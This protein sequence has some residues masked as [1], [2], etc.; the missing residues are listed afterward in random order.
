MN[1]TDLVVLPPTSDNIDLASCQAQLAS[2]RVAHKERKDE[3]TVSMWS[4]SKLVAFV[5]TA[6]L[7]SSR[8]TTAF[9]VGSS[10]S[11]RSV[12]S[13]PPATAPFVSSPLFASTD[14]QPA[15]KQSLAQSI[16]LYFAPAD[17]LT[18]QQRLAKMGLMAA[19]SYGWVSNTSYCVT[20]SIAWYLFSKRVRSKCR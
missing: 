17:G 11:R 2:I 8:M 1:V 16:R 7:S 13:S 12:V 3:S 9:S 10:T 19:L 15:E 5:V 4:V 18:F 6:L 20:V 14:D